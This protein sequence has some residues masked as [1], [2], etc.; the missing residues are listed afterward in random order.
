MAIINGY[1]GCGKKDIMKMPENE[2]REAVIRAFSVK[3][4]KFHEGDSWL[5]AF[6]LPDEIAD[7]FRGRV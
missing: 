5:G 1:D 7:A 4:H 2:L 6:V 3:T